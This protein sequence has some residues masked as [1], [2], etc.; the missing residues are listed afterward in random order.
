MS[1]FIFPMP[2]RLR[3]G[4]VEDC[5]LDPD[6]TA[7]KICLYRTATNSRSGEALINALHNGKRVVAVVELAA[8]R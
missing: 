1:C 8:I 7:I 3:R 4:C 2:L 6:V 5:G